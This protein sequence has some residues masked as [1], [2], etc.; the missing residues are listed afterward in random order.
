MTDYGLE[1]E[2]AKP[3]PNP[4]AY[5]PPAPQPQPKP[6]PAPKPKPKPKPK[7]PVAPVVK[8][9]PVEQVF[10]ATSVS[11]KADVKPFAEPIM[12]DE[13]DLALEAAPALEEVPPPAN[14]FLLA[15]VDTG[16]IISGGFA[17]PES[18]GED[19]DVVELRRSSRTQAKVSYEE[20]IDDDELFERRMKYLRNIMRY[21]PDELKEVISQEDFKWF[22]RHD[23]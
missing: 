8:P 16:N 4:Y 10:N 6:A 1:R 2:V 9:E 7:P 17:A 12:V 5:V 21:V 19:E 15:V 23:I 11:M 22:E 3:A 13:R 18:E 20:T 14:P